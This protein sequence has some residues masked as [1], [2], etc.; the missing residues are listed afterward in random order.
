M[1]VAAVQFAVGQD[2][3]ANLASCLRMI[4]QAA[5]ERADLVVLPNSATTCRGTTTATMPGAWPAGP[6]TRS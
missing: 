4:D 2:V 6:A 5:A 3:S 1:R